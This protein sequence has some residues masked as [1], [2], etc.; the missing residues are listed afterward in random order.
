M[1]NFL[2]H[3]SGSVS[4]AGNSPN[5]AVIE[6][7]ARLLERQHRT[8]VA[9]NSDYLEFE[10]VL[11]D[12]AYD[13]SLPAMSYLE[14]GRLW[15]AQEPQG[16]SVHYDLQYLHYFVSTMFGIAFFAAFGWFID[17]PLGSFKFAFLA[18]AFLF[19]INWAA[20]N[21]RIPGAIR[22]AIMEA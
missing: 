7:L 3:L 4:I 2:W 9:R 15:I 6:S 19:G 5:A 20:L 22:K 10:A 16:R 8:I 12:G 14:H 11:G 21:A 13:I 18:A 1:F 17:G